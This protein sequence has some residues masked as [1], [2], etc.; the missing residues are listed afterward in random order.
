MPT[1]TLYVTGTHCASCKILIED[2]LKSQKHVHGVRVDLQNKTVDID[3]DTADD[4]T[5][6]AVRLRGMLQPHGYD[7]SA[8]TPVSQPSRTTIG[9]PAVLVGLGVLLA[10]YALQT[11]G[12]LNVG[13]GSEVTPVTSMMIGL[14]ASVSS[15]LAVVGGLVLSLS[16]NMSRDKVSDSKNFMLFHGGRLGGFAILGGVLGAVGGAIGMNF[17]VSAMLGI[18]AS[19]V[20]VLLG[21]NLVGV[22]ARSSIMLPP[23]IFTFLRRMECKALAPLMLGVATFFLPCGFTQAMQVVALSSG[24]FMM[25]ALIMFT[26]ALGT[27][28]VLAFLSFGSTAFAKGKHAPV[29]FHA[30]GIVVIGLGVFSLLSGLASLGIIR[31]LL[32]L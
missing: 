18:A 29:F 3:T 14:L 23:G 24:S 7:L 15:C 4:A 28:P 16:A 32:S 20:M 8:H 13:F 22:F 5:A 11:S 19:V 1:T 12:I 9:W 31:P 21:L 2:T 26:F 10:F 17:T 25:G 27:F 30:A 6:L